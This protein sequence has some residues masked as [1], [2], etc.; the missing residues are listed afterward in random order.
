MRQYPVYNAFI[1]DLGAE[2]CS[3]GSHTNLNDCEA[4][5]GHYNSKVFKA[6][7]L[8][9]KVCGT[10][11]TGLRSFI[12]FYQATANKLGWFADAAAFYTTFWTSLVKF[13][14]LQS[15][16]S[17]EYC[18][19]GMLDAPTAPDDGACGK[20]S[21]GVSTRRELCKAAS[22][23]CSDASKGY[24]ACTYSY[25]ESVQ[26][27]PTHSWSILTGPDDAG[28]SAC[29]AH[30]KTF[31]TLG[32]CIESI[33]ELFPKMGSEVSECSSFRPMGVLM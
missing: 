18:I 1:E 12:M 8:D 11:K 14:C 23:S 15:E 3:V 2:V 29:V 7:Y 13:L 21:D 10:G 9:E 33:I 16:E 20:C 24:Q 4:A 5:G 19:A 28:W 31:E 30:L 26:W 27:T 6:S 17:G 22:G 32:C 25:D